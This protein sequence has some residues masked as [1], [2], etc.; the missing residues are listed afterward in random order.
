MIAP[1]FGPGKDGVVTIAEAPFLAE[2]IA[3]GPAPSFLRRIEA[4]FFFAAGF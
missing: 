1:W 4:K 3:D 2:A